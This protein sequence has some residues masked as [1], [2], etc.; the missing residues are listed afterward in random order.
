MSEL[1]EL[2]EFLDR[3]DDAD[4]HYSIASVRES[5]ITIGIDVPGEHWEVE[6]MEDGDIEVEIFKSDGQIFDFS[7]IEDL[8]DSQEES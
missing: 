3:L 7:I 2:T 5:V 4:I 6:F 1:S 8:F